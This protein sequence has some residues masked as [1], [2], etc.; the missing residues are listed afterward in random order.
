VRYISDTRTSKIAEVTG[1]AQ[2]GN[3]AGPTAPAPAP[4]RF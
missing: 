4:I 3:A 2:T 1:L